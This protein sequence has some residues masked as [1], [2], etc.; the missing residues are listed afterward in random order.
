MNCI[1]E[2]AADVFEVFEAK[3]VHIELSMYA[4]EV[5]SEQFVNRLGQA[6]Q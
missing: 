4:E 5:S 2:D 1:V 3:L 6:F